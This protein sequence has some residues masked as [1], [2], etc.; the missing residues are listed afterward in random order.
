MVKCMELQGVVLA[1]IVLV[2]AFYVLPYVY[3]RRNLL[4]Q[5]SVDDGQ[6]Q[7][8]RILNLDGTHTSKG[9]GGDESHDGV[10]RGRSKVV[11]SK[12]EVQ[13]EGMDVRSLARERAKRRA[14][15]AKRE[16]NRTRGII[17]A[18]AFGALI[19]ALWIVSAVFA[20]TIV[21]PI[22]A[23]VL[24]AAY[25]C[26]LVYLLSQIDK[27]NAAD[28][29]AI[30]ELDTQLKAL[31]RSASQQAHQKASARIGGSRQK[32][33]RQQNSDISRTMPTAFLSQ[34]VD[35]EIVMSSSTSS[36]S[37]HG[38]QVLPPVRSHGGDVLVDSVVH[39]G[40]STV[41]SYTLK[42]PEFIQRD[43]KPYEPPAMPE[44]DV[45]YRPKA[46]GERLG[47]VTTADDGSDK[48]SGQL[49]GGGAVLD[50][51]LERRRA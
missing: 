30:D 34:L 4:S 3:R 19:V 17:A 49:L 16:A 47:D 1:V 39:A 32:S 28:L 24:F 25:A 43:I 40:I 36:D 12:S 7:D 45:P 50:G 8:L 10:F 38:E 20:V 44:A 5:A 23:S 22:V 29:D 48:Q 9:E 41:P 15:I 46:L 33:V 13:G 35:E 18:V 6:S 31:R 2:S 14:R 51:I 21:L 11:M 27:A 26:A 42:R 37:S